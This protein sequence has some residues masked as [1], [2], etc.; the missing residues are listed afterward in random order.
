MTSHSDQIALTDW[1]AK[2]CAALVV[3]IAEAERANGPAS[4]PDLRAFV[5]EYQA[6]RARRPTWRAQCQAIPNGVC[7][8]LDEL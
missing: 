4:A 6:I 5:E 8:M 1:G 7:T 2:T 3:L